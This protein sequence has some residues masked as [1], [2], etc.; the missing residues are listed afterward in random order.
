[1][2]SPRGICSVLNEKA[3]SLYVFYRKERS[4]TVFIGHVDVSACDGVISGNELASTFVPLEIR[5]VKI[6]KWPYDAAACLAEIASVRRM[7]Y[8]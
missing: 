8:I 6:S 4:V 3:G 2:I 7:S 1:M 5:Y